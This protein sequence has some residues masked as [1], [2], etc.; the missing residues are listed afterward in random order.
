MTYFWRNMTGTQTNKHTHAFRLVQSRSRSRPRSSPVNERWMYL[1]MFWILELRWLFSRFSTAP[2]MLGK[3]EIITF[4]L[5]A[6]LE[7][8][9]TH[10]TEKRLM[11]S[12]PAYSLTEEGYPLSLLHSAAEAL[13]KNREN[14]WHENIKINRKKARH[15]VLYSWELAKM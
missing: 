15:H 8:S 13:L 7:S 12:W 4:S 3:R 14:C 11:C 5:G 2:S 10:N 9:Y 1:L 6:A